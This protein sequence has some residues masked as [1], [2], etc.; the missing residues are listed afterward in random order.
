MKK[1]LR[2]KEFK[3]SSLLWPRSE[4]KIST[5]DPLDQFPR[6]RFKVQTVTRDQCACRQSGKPSQKINKTKTQKKEIDPK[7][8]RKKCSFKNQRPWTNS[9]ES[10]LTLRSKEVSKD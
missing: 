4:G 3:K 5:S 10:S 8:F 1:P 2:S 6:R 7:N 9:S